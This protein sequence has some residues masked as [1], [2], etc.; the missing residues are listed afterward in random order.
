M[1]LRERK[2]AETRAALSRAALRLTVERGLDNV[3]VEDIA[4][5]AGVSPRTFDNRCGTP[6]PARCW[7]S[8]R[9]TRLPPST[10]SPAPCS[11]R[12]ACA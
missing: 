8:S 1:G 11:G 2:K 10:P 7:R 4:E 12:R 6:S 9:P 3:E 5:A